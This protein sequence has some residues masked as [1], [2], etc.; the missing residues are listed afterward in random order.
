[1]K[2]N[3][4]QKRLTMKTTRILKTV[5]ILIIIIYHY[6][7]HDFESI[8]KSL[9]FLIDEIKIPNKEKEEDNDK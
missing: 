1:M 8:V 9:F 4:K 5:I 3:T 2:N 7:N 6:Q